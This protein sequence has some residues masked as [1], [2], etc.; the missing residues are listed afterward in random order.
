M[1]QQQWRGGDLAEYITTHSRGR[2]ARKFYFRV[3]DNSQ[4]SGCAREP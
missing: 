1:M 2:V 4:C 3:I